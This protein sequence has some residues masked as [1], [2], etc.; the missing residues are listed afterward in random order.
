MRLLRMFVAVLALALA[1]CFS[2]SKNF[3]RLTVLIDK[4]EQ[5][6]SQQIF[7]NFGHLCHLWGKFEPQIFRRCM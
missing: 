7:G 1:A 5:N 2:R 3:G 6:T 4:V